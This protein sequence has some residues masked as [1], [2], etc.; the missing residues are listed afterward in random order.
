MNQTHFFRKSILLLWLFAIGLCQAQT[1]NTSYKTQINAKLAG[2]D[3]N[4]IATG[5]LLNQAMEFAE[6]S[7]YGGALTTTNWATRAKYTA[8]YNTLLMACVRASV[9][10]LVSPTAF[11]DNWDALRAP[12]TIILSGLYF[13]YNKFRPD[14]YP[15]YLVNNGGVVTDKY[16]GG[17]W[18]NPY[19]DQQVFAIAAPILVYKSLSLQVS[20]PAS[21]WY[22]NQATA[23]QSI[24]VDFG[25]GLGYQ[26]MT[27]GQ[28]RTINYDAAGVFE[29]KYKLTLTNAQI[30]YS[31]S[32]LKID[33]PALLLP[34]TGGRDI[35]TGKTVAS[36]AAPTCADVAVVPFAGTR[37][38]LGVA[39]TATLQIKYANSDCILRKP[40]IVVEGFD[41]GLT[42]TE[43]PFGEV[44]YTKFEESTYKSYDLYFQVFSYDVIYVNFSKGRDYLQRN[45][46]LVE[47]IIKWV[48]AKKAVAGITAPNVVIGQSMGGV[49]ARYALRDMEVSGLAHQANLFISHDAPQ[50]GAN[51][52][53]G[54]Q[55]FVR[56]LA[57]QF[58][59]TPFGTQPISMGVSIRDI[60]D[61][62][63]A[64]GTRQLLANSID[65]NSNLNNTAFNTFQT[66]LRNLG[67]PTQTRNIALS[68]GSHCASPQDF[69]PGATLFSLNGGAS[70]TALGTFAATLLQP[71]TSLGFA[72]SAY[73]FNEPGL[74]LGIL[75]GSSKFDMNF[76]ANALP[77]AGTSFP[78]YQGS[79][80]YTKKIFSLFGWDP[81]ITV[82]LTDRGY[83]N[84]VNLSYDYYPGGK[85]QLPFKF[86]NSSYNDALV[87]AGVSAYLAPTYNFIPVT[88]ALDIG[89]GR[90][91]LTNADYLRKYTAA[92]PPVAPL[93]SPFANFTTSLPDTNT[94]ETHIS[95]NN[96]NGNWL[97][98][99]L[100]NTVVNKDIFDCSY[101]CATQISGS[102]S[103]CYSGTFSVPSG[104][105]YYRWTVTS[106]SGL[107]S[108]SGEYTPN[109][110]L[111][112][113]NAVAGS[114]TISVTFGDNG[115]LCGNVTLTKTV[116][117]G[118][119][120]P[121]LVGYDC[122]F[123][124]SNDFPC[125][126][127]NVPH[128]QYSI[129]QALYLDAIGISNYSNPSDCEW[130]R[131]SDRFSF[132]G[133]NANANGITST[134]NSVYVSF[135][136]QVIPDKIE[137]R[138]RVRN[139]CGWSN[140]KN[141]ILTFSDGVPVALPPLPP[142]KY[143][144]VSPNP[145]SYG[146][147][148]NIINP[149]NIPYYNPSPNYNGP[150]PPITATL[151]D[152][153]GSQ[154]V[155]TI[156]LVNYY[157][158]IGFYNLGPYGNSSLANGSYF[159]KIV[160]GNYSETHT[161]IKN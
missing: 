57:D 3:K 109:F 153:S 41:T 27:F 62:L 31:H 112:R 83:N 128:T 52:P 58:L 15:N 92:T 64:P 5:L 139:S 65:I 2:L 50:Q 124:N 30:L 135:I 17:V 40:L 102:E 46:Y 21:L 71:F 101:V 14:A 33:I 93:N 150:I 16:V 53:L 127:A 103:L 60:Q 24:A 22:T 125:M 160:Y 12:N 88:S 28:M 49:I 44:S 9:P 143:F 73:V 85:F 104:Y 54:V 75:P 149:N 116:K 117:V 70:T 115:R 61:L 51:I 82:S 107:V 144:S 110:Y 141:F 48:N 114:V 47:D 147:T 37:P 108:T 19:I 145:A 86:E 1:V 32:K 11:D 66:E 97:A 96:R 132:Y 158:S 68:N 13:K 56:H 131:V 25:D 38:Y 99:E 42:N 90:A 121:T 6:L 45:A 59:A 43:N 156:T 63:D 29:W 80:S 94:N 133:I 72:G 84:P 123:G 122:Q 55:Y 120:P 159:L 87:S 20:L 113:A 130:E 129:S 148:I 140:W 8:V 151:Y 36:L 74:L 106:G 155:P 134:G 67:Y 76:K 100:N 105:S 157:G 23:V 35:S 77:A 118:T 98:K 4:K 78:I 34:P 39:N 91:V 69:S 18:Q 7:D 89:G 142:V 161:V 79:I 136:N 119:T 152:V 137:F 154:S 146:F 81:Q 26:P 126:I 111:T 10:G 95:F 138:C